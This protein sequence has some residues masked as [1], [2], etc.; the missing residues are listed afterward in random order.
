MKS[1][2]YIHKIKN[3]CNQKTTFIILCARKSSKKGYTNIPLT[4]INEN[5]TLIDRQISTILN[6][7]DDGEIIVVSG[8]EHDKIVDH[9]HDKKYANVRVAENKDYKSSNI[10]DGWRFALNI[11][12][13][14][15][16]YI[17]HGDRLFKDECIL[18]PKIKS[19]HLI[20]HDIDKNNYDLGLLFDGDEYI[21]MS[22]GLPN[23]WSEIF[24]IS[25]KDFDLA[26]KV[27]NEH[28]NR[29]IYNIEN[30]I[31]QLSREIKISVINKQPKD[32]KVLKEL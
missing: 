16:T 24:F 28:R 3:D 15:D 27:I 32:I 5:E 18:N 11:A 20:T 29:K 13:K 30:F 25:K 7:Y 6:N 21:N 8:F 19:S 26:R 14:E 2:R 17:I 12:L 9:I 31:N 1:K 22:Y 4:L 23:I 10:L